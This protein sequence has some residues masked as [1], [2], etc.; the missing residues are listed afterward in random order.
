MNELETMKSGKWKDIEHQKNV[1]ENYIEQIHDS[2]F[3]GKEK[4]GRKKGKWN[5]C[6]K[7]D[8]CGKRRRKEFKNV[9]ENILENI[10]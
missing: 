9:L 10:H 2:I 1:I 4:K 3:G 7:L 6:M 5:N 8:F